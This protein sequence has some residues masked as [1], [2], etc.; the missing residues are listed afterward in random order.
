MKPVVLVDPHPRSKDMIFTSESWAEL[1]EYSTPVAWFEGGRMPERMV[2]DHLAEAEIVIGQTPLDATRLARADRLKAV[3]NVK[4]NWEPGLDYHACQAR[5]IYVLS[6]AP[7]MAPAVAEWCLGAAIDL[8]RGLRLADRSFHEG[9]ERYGIAGNRDAR[10]LYGTQVGMVGF[11]N[12]GRALRPLLVPFGCHVQVY[13]PWLSTGYLAGFDCEAVGLE[14]LLRSADVIFILAGVTTENTHLLT[15]GLLR[16]IKPD[17]SVIL[18]SRAE[19]V[20][21]DALVRLA[22][23]NRFRLAVDVFPQEPVP[24][25][26]PVRKL[27]NA[28]LSAH[29]AGGIPASY[30]RIATWMLDDIRQI[31]AG[32][33]PLCLQRAEPSQAAVMRSR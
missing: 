22:A 21:F 14:R 33:P 32:H 23:E 12:L 15:E 6:I 25:E 13:D 17:T 30:R 1:T 10:S 27:A 29:R 31:L 7:C 19:I 4:G 28:T 11:G 24:A 9:R 20:D 3:I 26:A 16:R 5:G 18:A 8:G 2:E